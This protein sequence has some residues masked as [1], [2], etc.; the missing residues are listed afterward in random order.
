MR[1]LTKLLNEITIEEVK[2]V[3]ERVNQVADQ[4]STES[5]LPQVLRMV[6]FDQNL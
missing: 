6:A 3:N 4:Y 2:Q 5:E 1:N